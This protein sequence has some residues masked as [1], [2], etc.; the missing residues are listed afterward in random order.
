MR[1]TVKGVV[2]PGWTDCG[3]GDEPVTERP[4]ISAAAYY[5]DRVGSKSTERGFAVEFK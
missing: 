4:F 3:C 5:K 2:L 1:L